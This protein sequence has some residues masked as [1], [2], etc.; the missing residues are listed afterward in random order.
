VRIRDI[1]PGTLLACGSPNAVTG[2]ER[3]ALAVVGAAA[4]TASAS[5][6]TWILNRRQRAAEAARV[7]RRRRTVNEFIRR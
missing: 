2:S 5:L 1:E 7:D 3:L 6:T 4:F